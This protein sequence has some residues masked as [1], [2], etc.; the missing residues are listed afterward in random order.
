MTRRTFWA[1]CP[2]PIDASSRSHL[3]GC[4]ACASAVGELAGLPGLMSKVSEEQLRRG[5]GPAGDV[6]AVVG[7]GGAPRARTASPG[8]RHSGCRGGLPDRRGRGGHHPAGLPRPAPGRDTLL[9]PFGHREPGADRRRSLAGHR[10]RAVGR[11]GLGHP[12]R[13]DLLLQRQGVGPGRRVP[14]RAGRHRPQRRRPTG[15]DLEGTARIASS[16]SWVPARSRG[17]IA[18]VEVRTLS[19]LAILRL[20]TS[21]L[22]RAQPT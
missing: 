11:H 17:D 15:C 9:D 1:L 19:G 14:L 10:Q 4:A 8:C 22:I 21:D 2:R 3:K 7:P 12:H 6:A 20:S 18:A 16:P 5:R 13:P